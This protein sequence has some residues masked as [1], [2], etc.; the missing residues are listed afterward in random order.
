MI[1]GKKVMPIFIGFKLS[2]S[3]FKEDKQLLLFGQN[4]LYYMLN[5]I[6]IS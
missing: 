5:L 2:P 6:E 1:L 3:C 4:N